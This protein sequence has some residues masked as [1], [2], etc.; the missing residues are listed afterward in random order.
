[1]C[2]THSMDKSFDCMQTYLSRKTIPVTVTL[3]DLQSSESTETIS[4][5]ESSSNENV[6]IEA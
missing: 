4:S 6:D 1:M 5:A 3:G 2:S